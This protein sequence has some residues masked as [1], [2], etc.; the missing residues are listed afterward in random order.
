MI[1]FLFP[2]LLDN[3]ACLKILINFTQEKKEVHVIK[4]FH[5][6]YF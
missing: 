3:N 5:V 6:I 1:V 2:T 4:S